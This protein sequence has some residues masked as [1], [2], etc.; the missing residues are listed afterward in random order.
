MIPPSEFIALAEETH[1]IVRMGSW[2]LT[3][4]CMDAKSWPE[5][6]KV[7]VNL[8]AV[9]VEA[10]DI[11]GVVAQALAATGLDPQRL[12]LEITETVLKGNQARVRDVL[13]KLHD[14]GVT[15]ALDDFGTDFASLSYLRGFPFKKIKI[16]RSFV[17]DGREQNAC[18]AVM[19]SVADLAREFNIR[20]VAKGVETAA[21]LSVVRAAGYDEAQGFYFSLP[22]PARAAARTISQCAAK[23][24]SAN[25]AATVQAA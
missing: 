20:S 16:D 17:C 1:L 18:V 2:G 7:S 9:Q 12:Q 4:A 13:G 22:I 11:H 14:L 5:T 23:F 8:S 21:S 15:M 24:V 6:I 25:A 19:R 10:G 3:Q